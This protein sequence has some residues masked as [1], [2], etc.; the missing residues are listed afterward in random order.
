MNVRKRSIVVLVNSVQYLQ[1]GEKQ[2]EFK[3]KFTKDRFRKYSSPEI[4]FNCIIPFILQ[5]ETVDD[6]FVGC[7]IG[8]IP[9]TKLTS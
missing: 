3:M 6:I 7:N 8:A 4:D 9:K 2:M 1:T 5:Q